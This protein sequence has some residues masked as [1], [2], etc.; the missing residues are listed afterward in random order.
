MAECQDNTSPYHHGADCDQ[1]LCKRQRLNSLEQP[2]KII[3]LN[4]QCLEKIFKC[5]DLQS[6]FNVAIANEW[7]R[8]A[9]GY[10]YKRKYGTRSVSLDARIK[11]GLSI[12]ASIQ[13]NN[14]II[15]EGLKT[16]LLFLRCFG[17]SITCLNVHYTLDRFKADLLDEY[18]CTCCEDSLVRI[19]FSNNVIGRARKPFV[20]VEYVCIRNGQLRNEFPEWFPNVRQ[21]KLHRP[22]VG[23]QF[24]DLSFQHLEHLE[25][26]SNNYFDSPRK[27]FAFTSRLLRLNLQLRSLYVHMVGLDYV[28]I[29][30]ALLSIIKNHSLISKLT[31]DLSP[32]TVDGRSCVNSFELQRIVNEHPGLIEL[33]LKGFKFKAN[34]VITLVRQLKLLEKFRCRIDNNH[35]S[36]L[37]IQIGNDW[38]FSIDKY[39]IIKL[40]R[41]I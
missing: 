17:A 29:M 31:V 30:S 13:P 1:P 26:H 4:D 39:R 33:D 22:T 40:N 41:R 37:G 7:L 8:P 35:T 12:S 15:V 3:D 10:V 20:N 14:R 6:L 34:G 18:L 36:E 38:Q 5:L 9:A 32:W 2:T 25:L 16:S 28:N 27:C 11:N 19:E 24:S 23:Q 21:L